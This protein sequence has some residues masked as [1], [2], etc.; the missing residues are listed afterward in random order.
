M[1]KPNRK[2]LVPAL[3]LAA[4]LSVAGGT[5][6]SQSLNF[7]VQNDMSPEEIYVSSQQGGGVASI[8]ADHSA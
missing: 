7:V 1:A 6:T 5:A 8:N 3:A 4:S 2:P